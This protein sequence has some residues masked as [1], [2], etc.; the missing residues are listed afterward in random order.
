MIG[1]SEP[2]VNGRE[3]LPFERIA[4]GRL[5]TQNGKPNG[6]NRPIF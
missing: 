2:A 1:D 4:S 3:H 6:S 5:T